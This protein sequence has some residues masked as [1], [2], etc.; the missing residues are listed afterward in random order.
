MPH[1]RTANRKRPRGGR[2]RG[3][4]QQKPVGGYSFKPNIGPT[5]AKR[6]PSELSVA[7]VNTDYDNH[8]ISPS[9]VARKFGIVEFLAFRPLYCLELYQIYKYARITAVEIE[10]RVC[11]KSGSDPLMMAL[12]M[13][14][15]SD[16]S[17]L[18]PDR[19]WETPGTKRRLLS[20]KGGMDKGVLKKTFV[21]QNAYGQPYLD[22]KFWVDVT[23][24]AST[25]PIDANEPIAYYM[26]SSG[27]GGAV[28]SCLIEYKTT[29]HIQFFDLKIPSSSI[30]VD[31]EYS[32]EDEETGT[33]P[34]PVKPV[35]RV[36][37]KK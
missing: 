19:A 1:K 9:F 11:N 33:R 8:D 29:Y 16:F 18:T 26:L 20:T 5:R 24:S 2:K 6:I 23:Q 34:E 15:N 4:Y 27:S 14:P 31:T 35:Q 32:F 25:T 36:L 17:G 12:G 13:C 30:Q 7:L 37:K 3:G 21:G 10:L 22:Q 28:P